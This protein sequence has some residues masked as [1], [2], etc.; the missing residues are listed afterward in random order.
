MQ[1][2]NSPS[3][4]H[5][6]LDFQCVK[7]TSQLQKLFSLKFKIRETTISTELLIR[8]AGDPCPSLCRSPFLLHFQRHTR[9]NA[10]QV[11]HV[12][13]QRFYLRSAW[14]G[15][16]AVYFFYRQA[17]VCFCSY[18][19]FLKNA[20]LGQFRFFWIGTSVFKERFFWKH[21]LVFVCNNPLLFTNITFDNWTESIVWLIEMA[22]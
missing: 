9:Q 21:Q 4:F 19:T 3:S 18:F 15:A 12:T 7:S 16:A 8:S 17:M 22:G 10:A 13:Q 14:D 1:L 5:V 20:N 6:N 11:R 2:I